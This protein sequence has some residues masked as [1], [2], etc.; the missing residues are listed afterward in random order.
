M[1][2]DE[3]NFTE[4]EARCW[5][6]DPRNQADQAKLLLRP[7][8]VWVLVLVAILLVLWLASSPALRHPT[9]QPA[10]EASPLVP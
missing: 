10:S 4:E 9:M 6:D 7:V 1:G 2:D 8:A 3:L 5:A